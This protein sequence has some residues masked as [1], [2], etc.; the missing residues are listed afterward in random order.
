MIRMYVYFLLNFK[1]QYLFW[2]KMAIARWIH[3]IKTGG[4]YHV[5]QPHFTPKGQ[6]GMI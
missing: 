4:R 2:C 6:K 3:N 1:M 5:M